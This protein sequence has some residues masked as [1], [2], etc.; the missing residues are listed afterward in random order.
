ML[1]VAGER[2]EGALCIVKR[3][4]AASC[5][6]LQELEDHLIILARG[7]TAL[8]NTWLC[9]AETDSLSVESR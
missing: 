2:L 4:L 7:D 5:K 3:D 9:P 1:K 6:I 8:A